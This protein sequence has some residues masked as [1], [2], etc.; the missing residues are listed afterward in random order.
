MSSAIPLTSSEHNRIYN[1]VVVQ[2]MA[3]KV[4]EDRDLTLWDCQDPD[5]KRFKVMFNLYRDYGK[6]F[7]G[8]LDMK[9]MKR[10]RVYNLY[11]DR[12]K[13]TTVFLSKDRYEKSKSEESNV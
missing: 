11:N 10:K 1:E 12:R 13:K 5:M 2:L 9:I 6:E 7:S 3:I 8:D 4:Y